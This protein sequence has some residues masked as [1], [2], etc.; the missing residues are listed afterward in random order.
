M[1]DHFYNRPRVAILPL[2]EMGLEV[3]KE[4]YGILND[5]MSQSFLE[6]RWV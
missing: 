5:C 2:A 4:T 6:R 3:V 1:A